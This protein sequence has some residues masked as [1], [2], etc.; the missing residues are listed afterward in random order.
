[1][2]SRLSGTLH[3]LTRACASGVRSFLNGMIF[4]KLFCSLIFMF[5][6]HRNTFHLPVVLVNADI[7]KIDFASWKYVTV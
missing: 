5:C 4:L 3:L 7:R 6:S 2:K 1:M